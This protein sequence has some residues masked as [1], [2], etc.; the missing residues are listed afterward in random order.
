LQAADPFEAIRL[1]ATR[2]MVLRRGKIIARSAEK[3]AELDLPGRPGNVSPN[4][5]PGSVTG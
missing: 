5:T 2:L 3:T 1:K 4:F